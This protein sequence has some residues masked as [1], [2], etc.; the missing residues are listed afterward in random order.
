[1]DFTGIFLFLRFAGVM[2]EVLL[3]FNI[4]IIAHELGHFFAA[5]WRGM[6][7]EKF[8]I[9]FGPALFSKKI[10]GVDF[11]LGCIP[12]GGYVAIPQMANP[13]ILEGGVGKSNNQAKPLDKIIVAGAGPA[14]SI[15]C[16]FMFAV[17][18]WLVGK[19][20]YQSELTTTIG[21]VVPG[22]GAERAGLEAGD[23]ILSING[24]PIKRFSGF[25]HMKNSVVWNIAKSEDKGVFVE[26]DR[27][28]EVFATEVQTIIPEREGIG[29][30]KLPQIGIVPETTPIVLQV[31]AG[32]AADLGGIKGGDAILAVNGE[33]V[34]SPARVNELIHTGGA[35]EFLLQRN[36][37]EM[38][39]SVTPEVIDENKGGLIGVEWDFETQKRIEHPNPFGQIRGAVTVLFETL[40]AVFAPKSEIG[41]QHL[42]GPVG[43]M[44]LYYLLF[45]LPDGWR[46]ALWFSVVFNVNLAI[47]N[48]FPIPVLDGGHIL[49]SCIEWV[50]KKQTDEKVTRTLQVACTILILTFMLYVTGY[51]VLDFLEEKIP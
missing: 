3:I 22:S 47:L 36:E 30:R 29:R 4:I 35:L 7:V 27:A 5:K 49:M 15:I 19:P 9:W 16:G 51:D 48:L 12:A 34:Y 20:T 38:L 21:Y 40:G 23:K 41:A 46:I 18:V 39:I 14:A 25:S 26:I 37:G 6:D 11:R 43:I 50:R 32:G 8:G 17:V 10:G 13:E 42:S 2:M 28:G 1:M 33:R 45:E 31:I 24:T 44:R